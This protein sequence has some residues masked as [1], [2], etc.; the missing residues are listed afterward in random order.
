M[1]RRPATSGPFCSAFPT[2][3]IIALT[4]LAHGTEE[5]KRAHVPRMI[6]G[7]ELWVQLMSEPSGGSDLAGALTRAT[8]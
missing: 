1:P 3:A 5:Q 2:L 8:R 4:L 6:H 7:E